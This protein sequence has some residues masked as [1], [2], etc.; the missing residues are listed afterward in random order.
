MKKRLIVPRDQLLLFELAIKLVI[1]MSCSNENKV[2]NRVNCQNDVWLV[3]TK[4]TRRAS[5]DF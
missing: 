3:S 2:I 4:I 1:F 5:G